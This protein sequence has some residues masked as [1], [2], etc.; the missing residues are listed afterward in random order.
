MAKQLEFPEL[1]DAFTQ[2]RERSV[3]AAEAKLY[4]RGVDDG[5]V[6]ALKY[7]LNNRR[8]DEWQDKRVVEAGDNLAKSLQ[9]MRPEDR[10]ELL[11]RQEQAN[12]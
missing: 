9:S 1:N 5:D 12:V 4:S 7:I 11:E 10:L 2:G 3:D 6:P 8:P